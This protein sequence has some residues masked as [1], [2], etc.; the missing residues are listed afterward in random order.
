MSNRVFKT[1]WIARAATLLL[2]ALVVGWSWRESTAG[3]KASKG[4]LGVSVQELTPSLRK[5]MK[6]G[7]QTGLLITNVSRNSP[8]DDAG[9]REDDVI[10]EFD[11]KKVEEADAFSRMVRDAGAEKKVTVVLVREGE[12]KNLEVILGKRRSPSV[13]YAYGFGHG[14]GA[15]ALSMRPQL[16]VQVHELDENLAAYFKV[17]PREGVLVLEVTEDSPAEKAGL[18]SGDVITKVGEEAIRDAEDLMEALGEYEEGDK[19]AVAYVRQGKSATVEIEAEESRSRRHIWSIPHEGMG[20]HE[21]LWNDEEG[22]RLLLRKTEP[23]IELR[24]IIRD[25]VDAKVRKE[26]EANLRRALDETRWRGERT[27]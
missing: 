2:G 9:F 11:G 13:D 5:K 22:T 4:W 14:P 25:D 27:L 3:E 24:E 20:A 21:L 19:I 17:R 18:K 1:R 7:E 16:G 15:F 6:L 12:R 8:A 26:I 10:V 23:R